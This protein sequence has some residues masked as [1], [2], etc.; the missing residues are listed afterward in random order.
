[1]YIVLRIMNFFQD[2][3]QKINPMNQTAKNKGSEDRAG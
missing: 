3:G 2:R 1:M